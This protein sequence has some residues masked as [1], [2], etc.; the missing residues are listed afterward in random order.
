[1]HCNKLESSKYLFCVVAGKNEEDLSKLVRELFSTADNLECRSLAKAA[2][3]FP[4]INRTE[5]A[6]T[7]VTELT[8]KQT[9]FM[10]LVRFAG[11][12]RSIGAIFRDLDK[13][14]KGSDHSPKIDFGI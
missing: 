2:I 10:K 4:N 9:K 3:E 5:I 6:E 13:L 7:Y 8:S 11:P 12:K 14:V 1:M